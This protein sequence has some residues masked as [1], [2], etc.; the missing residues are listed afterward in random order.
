MCRRSSMDGSFGSGFDLGWMWCSSGNNSGLRTCWWSDSISSRPQTRSATRSRLAL[1][2]PL[3]AEEPV[4]VVDPVH[5]HGEITTTEYQKITLMSKSPA[6]VFQRQAQDRSF[7]RRHLEAHLHRLAAHHVEHIPWNRGARPGIR[8]PPATRCAGPTGY[9]TPGSGPQGR[10][11]PL[12]R[13]PS[14]SACSAWMP[15]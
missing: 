4:D 14:G 8:R 2:S 15:R 10:R 5:L 6:G 11:S 1:P 13:S 7:H 12:H 9:L 3:Q